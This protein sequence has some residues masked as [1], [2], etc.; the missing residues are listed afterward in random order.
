MLLLT[1]SLS[2][3]DGLER[4]QNTRD[5]GVAQGKMTCMQRRNTCLVSLPF[6]KM[7]ARTY[8]LERQKRQGQNGGRSAVDFREELY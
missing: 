2:P 3:F 5:K 6:A 7:A 4:L 1:R 8:C